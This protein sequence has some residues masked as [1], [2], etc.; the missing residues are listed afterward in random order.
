M[1]AGRNTKVI[2]A[3]SVL[4]FGTVGSVN[5][6]FFKPAAP[7]EA[8]AQPTTPEID[9]ANKR[10]DD[11]KSRLDTARKKLDAAKAALRAADAEFR[12]A[13]ADKEA[14]ALREQANQLADVSAQG[15][16]QVAPAI[17]K[18]SPVTATGLNN[19]IGNGTRIQMSG[20]GASV[21]GT[22]PA[23]PVGGQ[24]GLAPQNDY[25][26]GDAPQAPTAGQ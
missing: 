26:P 20:Q 17:P 9:A 4:I 16:A 18:A 3:L 11:A 14:L 22:V 8:E 19:G 23:P 7:G 1:I 5:A 25:D 13:K 2:L 12:A 6:S 15:D 24:D 21:Q 10:V